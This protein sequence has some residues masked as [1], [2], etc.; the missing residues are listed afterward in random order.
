MWL[1]VTLVALEVVY[2]YFWS[3]SCCYLLGIV[4]T[5][6]VYT[7]PFLLHVVILY[8]DTMCCDDIHEVTPRVSAMARCDTVPPLGILSGCLH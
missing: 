3:L 8:I 4:M 6:C 5:L 2:L 7:L 1:D